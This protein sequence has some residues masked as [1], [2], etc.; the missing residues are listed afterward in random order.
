MI[1]FD[2]TEIISSGGILLVSF[3]VFVETGLL[4]G[5]FLPGDSLLFTAGI[6]ASRGLFSITVLIFFAILAA[7]VGDNLAYRIGTYVG[8]KLF[9]KKNSLLFNHHNINKSRDFFEKHGGKS[10]IL[11]RFIPFARTFVPVIAGVSGMKQK[12]FMKFN[13][14]G[15]VLWAG[16]ITYLGY[17]LGQVIGDN[18]DHYLYP[19][20]LVIVLISIIPAGLEFILPRIRRAKHHKKKNLESEQVHE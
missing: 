17:S 10:I 4:I 9:K 12:D 2:L 7:I 5:F 11:A 20:I 15:A 6:L 19:L 1:S 13:F 18:I 14:I 16:G 8:P 3:I